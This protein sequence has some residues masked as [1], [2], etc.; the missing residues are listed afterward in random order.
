[1]NVCV[2]E[3]NRTAVETAKENT[4]MNATDLNALYTAFNNAEEYKRKKEQEEIKLKI[5]KRKE[6]TKLSKIAKD[7]RWDSIK[8]LIENY[9]QKTGD[10]EINYYNNDVWIACYISSCQHHYIH[11]N[12]R[13]DVS[14]FY[15]LTYKR[16]SIGALDDA[17]DK[18]LKNHT[19][20]EIDI[21][22]IYQSVIECIA[23]NLKKK[24]NTKA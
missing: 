24:I 13:S 8:D 12:G 9:F 19:A 2:Y 17:F 18:W 20:D 4:M 6:I 23:K 7:K 10:D 5:K 21:D 15:D 11:Y 22:A 1:M 3:R 16:L 14:I